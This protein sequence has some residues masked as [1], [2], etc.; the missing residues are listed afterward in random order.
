MLRDITK[1]DLFRYYYFWKEIE[2]KLFLAIKNDNVGSFEEYLK[3]MKIIRNFKKGSSKRVFQ[4]SG[5]YCDSS[6]TPAVDEL[7]KMFYSAGIL[8]KENKNANV[9]ASKILWIFDRKQVI[10]DSANRKKLKTEGHKTGTY[11][12][13][14]QAWNVEYQRA[15]PEIKQITASLELSRID[16][17]FE[18]EWFQMRVFDLYLWK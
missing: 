6:M 4:I 5:E 9:A 15:K 1:R 3:Y 7:S 13:Y 10:M 18:E 17:V 2:E 8:A 12:E 14:L 16:Q 11:F